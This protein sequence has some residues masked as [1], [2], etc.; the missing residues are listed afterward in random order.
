MFLFSVCFAWKFFLFVRTY[1]IWL[2]KRRLSL[3]KILINPVAKW[4]CEISGASL[5][6]SQWI[7]NVPLHLDPSCTLPH[8]FKLS[9]SLS[10]SSNYYIPLQPPSLSSTDFCSLLSLPLCPLHYSCYHCPPCP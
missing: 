5:L 8:S 10:T 7:C 4:L 9:Q 6:N 1:P 2:G 3:L